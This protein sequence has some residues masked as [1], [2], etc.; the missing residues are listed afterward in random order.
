VSKTGGDP[1]ADRERWDRFERKRE[2]SCETKTGGQFEKS[3]GRGL[4][5]EGFL[6]EEGEKTR[7]I[8]FNR[9]MRFLTI[10]R[11]VV[12]PQAEIPGEIGNECGKGS[13]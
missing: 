11:K 10:F 4:R 8:P 7:V 6:G 2:K 3:G 12:R 9:S 13:P 1:K 5:G